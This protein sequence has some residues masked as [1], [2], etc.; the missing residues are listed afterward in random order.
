MKKLLLL[1]AL[2]GWAHLAAA[3]HTELIGRA[4]L[5]FARFAGHSAE[6]TSGMNMYSLNGGGYGYTNNPCSRRPG[7]GGGLGVRLL[8]ESRFP[9]LLALDLG[10][11]YQRARTTIT[12]I[13]YYDEYAQA[14]YTYAADGHSFYQTQHLQLFAALGYRLRLGTYRLD[15]LAG[16]ELATIFGRRE[17][18]QGTY[19]GSHGW[20]TSMSY[21]DG[22][23]REARL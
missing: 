13:N 8:H 12:S 2:L 19:N 15:L 1:P 5:N 11:D 9:L 7:L 18:G 10:Y 14:N 22:A 17:T 23:P 4:G 6:G 21:S 16:P 20:A 3:Q